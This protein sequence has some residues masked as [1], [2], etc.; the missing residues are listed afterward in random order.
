M[1]LPTG[2]A[3]KRAAMAKKILIIDDEVDLALLL[4]EF[5]ETLGYEVFLAGT[6][7][8]GLEILKKEEPDLV[9][10]DIVMPKVDGLESLQQ[11]KSARPQSIVIV[12]SGLRDAELARKAIGFGAYDF[13]LKPL[14][15]QQLQ[16]NILS[17]IFPA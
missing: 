12:M 16:N 11:L 8:N 10:Q 9:F 6:A 2:A 13:L 15:L 3:A 5:L 14:D 7:A 1:T 4:K 17:R